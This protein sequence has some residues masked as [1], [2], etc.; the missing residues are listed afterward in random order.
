M[1]DLEHGIAKLADSI[2][3]IDTQID[4]VIIDNRRMRALLSQAALFVAMQ[5]PNRFRERWLKDVE[6][7]THV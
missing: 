3:A 2:A 6:E 1:A 4:K 5:P 7:L